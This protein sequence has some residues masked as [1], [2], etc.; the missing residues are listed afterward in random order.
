MIGDIDCDSIVIDYSRFAP[1]KQYLEKTYDKFY[2]IIREKHPNKKIILMTTACFNRWKEYLEYDEVI[3]ETYKSA[4][5][6]GENTVLL[7]Q[8][9]LFERDEYDLVSVDIGHYTDYGM[10]RVADKI[11]EILKS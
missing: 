11:C 5:S 8:M 6:R 4:I 1:D 2:R 9:E 10:F 3:L 7:N